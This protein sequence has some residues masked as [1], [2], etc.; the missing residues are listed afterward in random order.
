MKNLVFTLLIVSGVAF[1]R[2]PIMPFP[3]EPVA[4]AWNQ[5]GGNWDVASGTVT[6]LPIPARAEFIPGFGYSVRPPFATHFIV[7]VGPG[8]QRRGCAPATS[9]GGALVF[10]GVVSGQ[11]F[12]QPTALIST[13]FSQ[14]QPGWLNYEFSV[15]GGMGA[16][17]QAI[18]VAFQRT[19]FPAACSFHLLWRNVNDAFVRNAIADAAPAAE[20]APVARALAAPAAA[21]SDADAKKVEAIAKMREHLQIPIKATSEKA[22]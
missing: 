14:A 3:P 6:S 18:N 13:E 19:Q 1:G 11:P 4:E 17:I 2:S 21:L 22:K 16:T 12:L 8:S 7:R 10:T 20:G 5:V 15:N 9:V